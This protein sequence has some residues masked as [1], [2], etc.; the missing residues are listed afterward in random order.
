MRIMD[1]CHLCSAQLRIQG[2]KENYNNFNKH[3]EP[4]HL[5]PCGF[6]TIPF[7]GFSSRVLLSHWSRF[8]E[9]RCSDWWNRQMSANEKAGED[10][11]R[12]YIVK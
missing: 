8:V 11:L 12:L 2:L 10:L 3:W 9:I 6:C 7:T 5:S 4:L 1:I